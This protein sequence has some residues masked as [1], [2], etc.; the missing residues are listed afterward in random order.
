MTAKTSTK[1]KPIP[2]F[3]SLEEEAAYWDS[4]SVA[5][6]WESVEP[7]RLRVSKKLSEGVTVRFDPE[8]L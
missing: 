3:S 5:E 2:T 7:I 8:T 1:G 4:H 6:H